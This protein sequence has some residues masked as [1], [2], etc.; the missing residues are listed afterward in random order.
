[1]FA[2]RRAHA[3][4]GVEWLLELIKGLGAVR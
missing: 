1:V 4:A 2:V 3:D